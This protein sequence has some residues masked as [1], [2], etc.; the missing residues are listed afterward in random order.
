MKLHWNNKYVKWA[1]TIVGIF[2]TCLLFFYLLFFGK[3]F[4][5]A[6]NAAYKVLMPILFG[7][8]MAYLLTPTINWFEKRLLN[9]IIKRFNPLIKEKFRPYI[10]AI[11]IILTSLMYYI[12]IRMIITMLLS[13]IVPS[14]QNLANNFSEYWDNFLAW[15]DNLMNNKPEWLESLFSSY[16]EMEEQVMNIINNFSVE[17]MGYLNK[18]EVFLSKSG[19]FIKT[20]SV[21]LFNLLKVLWN[22]VLGFIIAIYLMANKERYANQSKKIIYAFWERDKANVIINNFRFAHNTFIGFIIGKVIDSIIIGCLCFCGTTLIGTP[23]PALVS[24][25]IGVTNVIPFFGPFLGA[26][27]CSILILVVDITHPLNFV[28]FVIFILFL[29]QLD[30]NFIGPKILGDST[31]LSSFWVIFA[32]T[33]FG[34]ILGIPGMIIGVPLFAIIYAAIKAHVNEKLYKK[35]F[36][37]ETEDYQNIECIDN[38]GYHYYDFTVTRNDKSFHSGSKYISSVEEWNFRYSKVNRDNADAFENMPV[39]ISA[40]NVEGDP[41]HVKDA[42]NKPPQEKKEEKVINDKKDIDKK[43]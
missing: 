16:P 13:Q 35:N 25:V 14:V 10:R 2:C 39:V 4:M 6:I 20:I 15:L 24:V 18:T 42:E 11:S 29:Q 21:S 9:P 36:S 8:I 37:T 5:T 28:Y 33:L 31:G 26:I 30:G 32:I 23:Y 43:E 19:E 41:E 17:I 27:P 1:V 34:G 22:F 12:I 38:N 40:M 3:N 7:C